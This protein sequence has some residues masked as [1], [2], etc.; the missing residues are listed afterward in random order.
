MGKLQGKNKAKL[1]Q[2]A[3]KVKKYQTD[4]RDRE[5]VRT[6]KT[7]NDPVL[8]EKCTPVETLSETKELLDQMTK[9]LSATKNGVGLA[10]SQI[11]KTKCAFVIRE[12]L[13]IDNFKYYI[14]PE[15]TKF[16]GKE[17]EVNE[18]CLSYPK[19]FCHVKRNNKIAVK[20]LDENF[21]EQKEILQDKHGFIF[22]HEYD[23][24]QGTCKVGESWE[25]S[26]VNKD[27]NSKI[28]GIRLREA[29]AIAGGDFDKAIALTYEEE[30]ELSKTKGS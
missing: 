18:G 3:L 25:N 16:I 5:L 21:V 23:H 13:K 2:Q 24:L 9:V 29:Q 28:E 4:F 14:N 27:S 26:Q 11:G 22:Q 7:F 20:Y 6:I 1:R 15:I 10:A 17:V 19:V 8:K 30:E 12:D